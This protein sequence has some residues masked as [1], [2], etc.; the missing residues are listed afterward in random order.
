MWR[1][2]THGLHESVVQR[3]KGI[4]LSPIGQFPTSPKPEV[5][6]SMSTKGN[7]M[8]EVKNNFGMKRQTCPVGR[9]C[10]S[11]GPDVSTEEPTG[12]VMVNGGSRVR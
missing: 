5:H 7:T 10:F 12:S 4:A 2:D 9:G 6:R 8:S 1:K 3:G 11:Q